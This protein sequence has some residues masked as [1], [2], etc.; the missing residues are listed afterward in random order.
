MWHLLS[1]SPDNVSADGEVVEIDRS[2]Q[3]RSEKELLRNAIE[4]MRHKAAPAEV[5][6]LGRLASSYLRAGDLETAMRYVN[7]ARERLRAGAS[8]ESG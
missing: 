1:G 2:L 3:Q 6:N 5:R 4:E 7:A 8:E